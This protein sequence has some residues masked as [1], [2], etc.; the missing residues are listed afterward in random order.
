MPHSWAEL[1]MHQRFVRA[2][3]RFVVELRELFLT[4][5]WQ[6]PQSDGAASEE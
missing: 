3:T 6:S 5:Q 2:G 4:W 1:W